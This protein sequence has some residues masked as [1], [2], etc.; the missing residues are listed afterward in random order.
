MLRGFQYRFYPTLEQAQVL[1][2][3]LGCCRLVYNKAL[4]ERKVAWNERAES[5]SFAQQCR[6]LTQWKKQEDLAFLAEVSIVPLQQSLRSLQ[7]GHTNFFE[8]RA[9]HPAFKKRHHGGSARYMRN[10]FRWRDG[11]LTLARM[12]GPLDIHWSRPL[13]DGVEPSSVTVRVDAAGRWF[14]SV[15]CDDPTLQPLPAVDTAVG[16][17][18]GLHALVTLSTGEKIANPRHDDRALAKKKRLSRRLARKQKGS[19]NRNKARKKL[20]RHHTR[21][22]DRRRD[23]LHQVSTRLVR[24]NQGS[25]SKT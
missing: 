9:R 17:D 23:H 2:R 20:A 5:V 24:E 18:L 15:L 14:V 6:A 16:L 4:L 12:D 11:Q 7:S 19:R 21:V 8:K 1:R 25:S 22:A 13:P 10:G 3:T